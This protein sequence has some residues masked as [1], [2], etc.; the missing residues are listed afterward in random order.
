P[1]EHDLAVVARQAPTS[2]SDG[3]PGEADGKRRRSLVGPSPRVIGVG[4]VVRAGDARAAELDGEAAEEDQPKHRCTSLRVAALARY[5]GAVSPRG[6]TW[7]IVGC[8]YTGERLARRLVADRAAVVA[9]RRTQAAADHLVRTLGV[10]GR[11]VDLDRPATV[12][13]A[14]P[15]GAVAVIAAPP[16][17]D[18][19]G[20]AALAAELRR[21]Q[22]RRV[23][24]LSS[25]GV[26]P[27]GDG[28]WV[29]EDTAPAPTSDHG[30]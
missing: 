3:S 10:T 4:H 27:P 29:D 20:D 14:C 11:V 13:G 1:V 12:A 30:R 15:T 25:T 2:P 19:S 17:A 8:G 23:V 22:A 18:P 7:F 28:G 16:A 24:Y 5:H 6:P 9:T 21:A 26:Y